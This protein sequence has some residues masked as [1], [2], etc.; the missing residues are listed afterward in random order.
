MQPS[1]CSLLPGRGGRERVERQSTMASSRIAACCLHLF[2]PVASRMGTG[3]WGSP[4]LHSSLPSSLTTLDLVALLGGS[5]TPH[6]WA[7]RGCSGRRGCKT[8]ACR[9]C[10]CLSSRALPHPTLGLCISG[11]HGGEGRGECSAPAHTRWKWLGRC[12]H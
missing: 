9:L 1:Q 12:L 5:S 6:G 8:T 7:G 2:C 11:H 10:G 3:Y 4:C